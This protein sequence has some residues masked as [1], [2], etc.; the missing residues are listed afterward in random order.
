MSPPISIFGPFS[1]TSTT[2]RCH[3]DS[4]CGAPPPSPPLP[5]ADAT[6][7]RRRAVSGRCGVLLVATRCD[8]IAAGA[9]GCRSKLSTPV[10]ATAIAS[11]SPLGAA[12]APTDTTK[13]TAR[14]STVSF[15]SHSHARSPSHLRTVAV[16]SPRRLIL[17]NKPSVT[18]NSTS[19]SL[20]PFP[21]RAS[22]LWFGSC[23]TLKAL[24][25][26]GIP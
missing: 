10:A 17:L 18:L 6:K 21:S 8:A 19:P 25:L 14:Q 15:I 9:P 24:I 4:F 11:N 1:W 20:A 16:P 22:F 3:R 7:T 13:T 2:K 5:G 23:V 12:P 26:P